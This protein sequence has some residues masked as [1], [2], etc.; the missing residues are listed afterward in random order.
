MVEFHDAPSCSRVT[1]S[2]EDWNGG[3]GDGGG[4]DG[5]GGGRGV[6]GAALS[7]VDDVVGAS[8]G[9]EPVTGPAVVVVVSEVVVEVVVVEVEVEVDAVVLSWLRTRTSSSPSPPV[10]K[11]STSA[12]TVA[13][14]TVAPTAMP[15]GRDCRRASTPPV[16]QPTASK[17]ARRWRAPY[18]ATMTGIERDWVALP[19]PTSARARHGPHPCQGLY[20]R[21]RG[22]RPTV[23]CIATHYN[24]DFS[25]HYLAARL[26][27]RGIGFLGWNTR[28]RGNEPYFLLEHAL[29][30]IGAGVRWLREE[31]GV[32]TV[33]ILGNSGG[34]SLMGAYLSQA[35]EPSIE[36]SPGQGLPDAVLDLPG[37]D[38]YISLNAHPGRPEV[39]TAWIDP[40][41]TD[42]TDPLSVDPDLDMFASGRAVPFEADFV[43]RYRAAQRARNHRLTAW[44]RAELVRLQGAGAWDRLFSLHRVWA[45]LRFADLSLDPSDRQ[46]GCYAGDPRGANY[47]PF[48]IGATSTL[49]TWLSMWSLETSQCQGRPHLARIRVPSLVVQSLADRGVFPSDAHTIH[50]ALAA[51]DKALELVAGEHYFETGGRDEVADLL[52]AWI[53]QRT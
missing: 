3:A 2:M 11:T 45:D 10:V 20:H 41:V 52:A 33:V 29:V 28:Y 6:T 8:V 53:G 7:T 35:T 40:S 19:S 13:S 48:A 9:T 44:A 50:D 5:G 32:D 16:S 43:S 17:A 39:L 27:D 1:A 37:A 46:A 38:L 12:M 15:R 4:G 25:E 14:T 47:G 23:A 31:A 42:E 49:R 22:T 21:P 51:E 26:A 18:V 34:G 30:D 36:A 24:V